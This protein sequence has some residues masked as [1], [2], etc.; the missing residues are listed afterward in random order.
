MRFVLTSFVVLF[1]LLLTAAAHAGDQA[2]DGA[3]EPTVPPVE[4][5]APDTPVAAPAPAPSEPEADES[6]ESAEE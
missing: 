4:A 6:A 1:G 5:A 2:R 3:A